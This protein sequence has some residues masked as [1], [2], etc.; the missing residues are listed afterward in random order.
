VTE[1]EQVPDF[2][3]DLEG[4]LAWHEKHPKSNPHWCARH[5]APC[6]V[7]GAPGM[8]A[9]LLLAGEAFALLPDD[10]TTPDAVNSWWANVTTPAC[11]QLGDERIE[12][13]WTFVGRVREKG[14]TCLRRAPNRWELRGRHTCF[15]EKGH[16]GLHDWDEPVKSIFA[17]PG[18]PVPPVK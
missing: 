9:T 14:V 2:T 7:E 4:F 5:W 8:L 3:G 10:V 13:L 18:S 1:P 6:P 11:C 16:D 17:Y 12:W 15:Y